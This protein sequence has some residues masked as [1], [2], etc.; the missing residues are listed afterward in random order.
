MDTG[1]VN[2]LTLV[3]CFDI[4]GKVTAADA[5][6]DGTKLAVLTYKAIWIFEI[7]P[8]TDHY[9]DGKI[10]WLPIQIGQCE[11]ICFDGDRLIISSDEGKG[12]L[13]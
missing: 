6:S 4:G 3:D 13:Y 11:A 1:K 9:F 12:D 7:P 10:S 8:N 2:S 5:T